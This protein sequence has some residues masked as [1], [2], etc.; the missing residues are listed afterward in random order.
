MRGSAILSIV[1]MCSNGLRCF[2]IDSLAMHGIIAGEIPL[3]Y[4]AMLDP[5]LSKGA[6]V[7]TV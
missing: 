2:S 1:T 7:K 3:G 6:V 5:S 4:R